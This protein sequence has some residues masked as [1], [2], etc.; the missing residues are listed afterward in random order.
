MKALVYTDIEKIV[1][2]DYTD[3]VIKTGESLIKVKASGI[4]GSDMHAYHGKDERRVPPL[5][6][7]H[8]ITGVIEKGKNIGRKVII[9]PLISCGDCQFCNSNSEHLCNQRALI[10]M[11]KPFV[12][13]GGLAEFVAVPDKNIK[14]LPEKLDIKKAAIS[15]P[16]AVSLHAVE[17]GEKNLK[18]SIK[19]ANILIIG[20]GAI[21]ILSALILEN[22]KQSNKITLIEINEKRLKVCRSNLRSKVISS[23]SKDLKINSFDFVIDA[24]GTEK[25]RQISIEHA[26]PGS[27]IVH[28]GLTNSDGRFNSRKITLQEISFI[29]TYCYT[30]RDFQNSINFLGDGL[31]G[32]LKWIEYR[33]LKNGAEAF[34]QIHD[35]TCAAPK[36]VLIPEH[37]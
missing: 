28:A 4:C 3:P 36:I 19:D 18:L 1:Y 9:N 11:N 5:I 25:T 13:E 22:I 37:D 34:R 6:L 29:G 16:T 27:V 30:T 33:E 23:N 14:N 31:I 32:D 2:K 24:V 8:E 12:K 10:G 26:K 21:G 17:L 15:E 35:G 20:G 7:G